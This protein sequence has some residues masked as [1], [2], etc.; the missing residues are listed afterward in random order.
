MG[1]GWVRGLGVE[2]GGCLNLRDLREW[3]SVATGGIQRRVGEEVG[4]DVGG[5]MM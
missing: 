4:I 2:S 5:R 3:A 1:V